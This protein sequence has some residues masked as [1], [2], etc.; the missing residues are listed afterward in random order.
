MTVGTAVKV[1]VP[2]SDCWDSGQG[3]PLCD[4]LDKGQ[5]PPPCVTTTV[6]T[7]TQGGRGEP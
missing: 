2:L 7:V 1:K 5:G 3:P 6:P 4:S